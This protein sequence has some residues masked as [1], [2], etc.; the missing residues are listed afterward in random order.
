MDTEKWLQK[1]IDELPIGTELE[2]NS[3]DNE[4]D[5]KVR[6]EE[7]FEIIKPYGLDILNSEET[8]PEI[9]EDIKKQIIEKLQSK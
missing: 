2:V 9:L 4:I 3:V 8:S 6:R 7:L 5:F 1:F